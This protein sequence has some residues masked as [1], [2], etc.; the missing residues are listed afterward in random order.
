M[1]DYSSE[2]LGQ[3]I[4]SLRE[5]QRMTQEELGRRAGYRTGAGVSISRLESGLLRPGPDRLSGVAEG[6]G[7][8]LEELAARASE[9]TTGTPGDASADTASASATTD[10]GPRGIKERARRIE[11]E[12]EVRTKVITDLSNAFNKQHDRA[13]DEF[14]MRFAAIA[15]RVEGAPQP[16]A[17]EL[18]GDES[19][20]ADAVAAYRLRSNASGVVQLLAGGAGGAAAGAA[21]GGAVA[22][23]TFVAA[24]SFG[25]ASTGAAIS[26]L[27]GIAATNATLALLGGGTLAA[28][29]AGVAGGTLV[30]AGIVAAPAVIL[31][32]G[33]LLWMVKRNRKQQQELAV[34]LDEAE[35]AL[36]E[37]APGLE[38]LENILPQATDT[39]DYIATHASHALTRWDQRLPTG[40]ITW[41]SLN[42]ADQQR[43]EDFVEIAAAQLAI[44]TINVQGLLTARG[45]DRD[46]LIQLAD[47]VLRQS[48][49]AVRT[50]V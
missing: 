27:S 8:T 44:V 20:G 15:A 13:R 21:V 36:A 42:S 6:L 46:Q 43:Y 34:K 40:P 4:R 3:V 35:A 28:G 39:L 16:G 17:I 25:A 33:G 26:G 31:F 19:A 10:S 30:L 29:G 48:Q 37:T 11:H 32:A 14:F 45:S 50:R 5:S 49:D 41:D 47:Q 22:Y 24:A 2:A 23:G 9:A 18:D 38:A 1:A 7:L 12:V